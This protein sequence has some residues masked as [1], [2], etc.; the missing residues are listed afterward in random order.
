MQQWQSR[1]TD[2][3][4]DLL[5]ERLREIVRP[6]CWMGIT[7]LPGLFTGKATGR[8]GELVS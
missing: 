8:Q 2:G 6:W 3:S 4:Y 5:T 7:V 1:G